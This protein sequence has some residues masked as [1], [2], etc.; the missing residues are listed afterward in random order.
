MQ[1]SHD[2]RNLISCGNDGSICIFGIYD[3]ESSRGV[4]YL[5]EDI[6]QSTRE[7]LVTKNELEELKHKKDN[8]LNHFT[9]NRF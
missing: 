1:V 6:L 2:R 4:V 8:L 3:N 9:D 7:I 5:D